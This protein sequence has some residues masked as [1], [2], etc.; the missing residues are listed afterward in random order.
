MLI[1]DT[2][3]HLHEIRCE[4]MMPPSQTG[5]LKAE[6][7]SNQKDRQEA[8]VVEVHFTDAWQALFRGPLCALVTASHSQC[9]VRL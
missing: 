3:D 6:K 8:L 4:Q 5:V 7:V 2:Q 9:C 1:F